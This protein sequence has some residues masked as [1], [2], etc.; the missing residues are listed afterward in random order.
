MMRK[1]SETLAEQEKTSE[2]SAICSV[3]WSDIGKQFYARSGWRPFDS[4][5]VEFPA[6]L[7]PTTSPDNITTIDSLEGLAPLV[8]ADE[9][10]LRAK[11][12]STPQSP[13]TQVALLPSLEQLHWHLLRERFVSQSLFSEHTTTASNHGAIYTSPTSGKRA[14]AI[15]TR[16][17]SGKVDQ[18]EKNTLY[19]LRLVV[20]DGITDAE[21][22]TALQGITDIARHLAGQWACGKVEMWNP[23]EKIKAFAEAIGGTYVSRENGSLPALNWFGKGPAEN[24]E[25]I[26]CEKYAWC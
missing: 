12:D 18:P 15:W 17:Y 14:W 23:D 21:L 2:G 10:I 9:A 25:W 4:N 11:F 19:F 1:L 7:T 6:V 13:K 20:E 3:L 26:W 22:K 24:V 8:E 5:H 16:S